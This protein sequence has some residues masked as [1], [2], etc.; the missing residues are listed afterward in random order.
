MLGARRD[1][2]MADEKVNTGQFNAM[3]EQLSKLAATPHLKVVRSEVGSVLEKASEYTRKA[4]A[5]KI[6]SRYQDFVP[7]GMDSYSPKSVRRYG[8][9]LRGNNLVYYMQNKYPNE[10]WN[11]L[12][13][14]RRL[15]VERTLAARGLAK[16]SWLEIA[17]AL[18][19]QIDVPD[20]VRS[21]MPKTGKQYTNAKVKQTI[22]K[23]KIQIDIST[24][25]PTVNAI[26]GA[27][28][29]ARAMKGRIQYFNRNAEHAV[30]ADVK[31]IAKAY[32]GLK[33]AA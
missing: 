11:A 28:A 18:G 9:N 25:Q 32:P 6:R 23:D 8:G 29:L 16:K 2:K 13:A 22:S 27:G 7:M 10:L 17:E 30:F 15:L 19:I 21:A 31:R 12:K 3:C 14:R 20:Y 1:D 26:G 24:A 5:G 4:S 33:L